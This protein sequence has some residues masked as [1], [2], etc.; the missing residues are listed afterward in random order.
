MLQIEIK[1]P[2]LLQDWSDEEVEAATGE[3]SQHQIPCSDSMKTETRPL[4][5]KLV[6][7]GRDALRPPEKK[8]IFTEFDSSKAMAWREKNVQNAW[9]NTSDGD[10]VNVLSEWCLLREIAW[11]LQL[12]PLDNERDTETLKKF[13]KF[14]SIN[15]S[16]DEIT[17]NTNVSLA[18]MPVGSL[19]TILS[20]FA[21]VSTELYRFRKFFANV[22]HTPAVNSFLESVQMAPYSI[23]CYANG[24]KDF[25]RIVSKAICDFEME[26]IGQD[27]TKTYTVIYLYNEL[28]PHFRKVRILYDIHT[29]VY[30]DFKTNAGKN[31]N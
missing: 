23:Q 4:R 18:N 14:F 3:A 9:W 8:P 6:P 15:L 11:T 31:A 19:Q 29:K 30:I 27:L 28:L 21:Q 2:N 22:F 16:T 7:F 12:Q 17:V 20:E 26:L 25:L 1:I 10:E 13:S 24:L 5:L